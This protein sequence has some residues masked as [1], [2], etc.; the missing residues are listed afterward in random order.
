MFVKASDNTKVY[1]LVGPTDTDCVYR[2]KSGTGVDTEDADREWD[3]NNEA[4]AFQLVEFSSYLSL[5]VLNEAATATT[6]T[7][8]LA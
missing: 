1:P 7:A 4:V 3:V 2:L 6:I 5:V 8:W